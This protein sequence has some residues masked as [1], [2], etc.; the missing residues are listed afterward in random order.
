MIYLEDGT[1]ENCT[2][3]DNAATV[4]ATAPAA[5][6]KA[7]TFRNNI[8]WGNTN[9]A[10]PAGC[11][12]A[13]ASSITYSCAPGLTGT[14][15]K[16][17]DPRFRGAARGNYTLRAQSPCI[18]AG[19]NRPWMEGAIDLDGNPRVRRGSARGT[20]DMGCFESN[21]AVGTVLYLK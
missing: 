6:A 17:E 7:G 10:G 18:D 4:S 21:G 8:V 16:A 11:T 13:A 3:A 19:L 1:V 14:G 12:A 5:Y 2:V 20:V 15:C 9:K